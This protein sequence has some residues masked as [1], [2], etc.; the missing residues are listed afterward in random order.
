MVVILLTGCAG[1]APQKV[2]LHPSK[3]TPTEV[4]AGTVLYQSDWSKG[5]GDWQGD[6]GWQVSD[7][8]LKT[9][10]NGMYTIT[11]PYTP[12]LENYVVE[13]HLK[14]LKIP[15]SGGGIE[16]IAD[17]AKQ[18]SGYQAGLINLLAPDALHTFA[19][20]PEA[21]VLFVPS[22]SS[23]ANTASQYH[24]FEPGYNWIT[25]RVEVKKSWVGLYINN[26]LVSYGSSADTSQLSVG[27]IHLYSI[28]IEV[29]VDSFRIVS[30]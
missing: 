17:P 20:H 25:Y 22:S 13:V 26:Q 18:K 16:V 3:P 2:T 21:L 11:S 12:Q 8:S 9:D 4:P 5:L 27:P 1:S 23:E 15:Q 6:S 28:K 29:Q 7:A 14:I 30:V 10:A 19:V 24:D